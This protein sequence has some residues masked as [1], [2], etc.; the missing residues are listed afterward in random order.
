[1]RVVHDV[2]LFDFPR[3]VPRS[4]RL[5]GLEVGSRPI[6][7]AVSDATWT[8]ATPVRT[9]A[10]TRLAADLGALLAIVRELEVGGFVVGLPMQMDGREGTRCQSVRQFVRDMVRA[11]DLPAAFWDERLSTAAV[12]RTLIGEADLSRKRRKQA[13]DRAAAAWILQGALDALRY[14]AA[15]A[16][17]D[18]GDD[19]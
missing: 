5:L 7:L 17:R 10:R 16:A 11:I 19:A 14:A 2:P 15:A 18:R 4:T 12:E 1:M 6:G 3:L 8:V 13:V 9:L